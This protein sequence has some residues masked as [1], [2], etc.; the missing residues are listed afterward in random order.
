M[1]LV[2][3][4]EPGRDATETEATAKAWTKNKYDEWVYS[5]V[6]RFVVVK[7][8]DRFC[9][10]I[11]VV[12]YQGQ[13]VAKKGVKKSDHAII[14]T[15]NR[16]PSPSTAEEPEF[17]EAGM[18]SRCIRVDPDQRDEKLDFM[19]RIDFS[20]VQKVQHYCKVK[21]FGKVNRDSLAALEYQY[22]AVLSEPR[23]LAVPSSSMES[24]RVV[25]DGNRSDP[26]LSRPGF[27]AVY[28]AL[29]GVQYTP[30][31][32]MQFLNRRARDYPDSPEEKVE[33]DKDYESETAEQRSEY[34][35]DT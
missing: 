32:A 22:R 26:L 34:T 27:Q 10:A 25:L 21:S 6:R 29:I 18:R 9:M 2:L 5:K 17:G 8:Q 4:S 35:S 33:Y 7:E 13:G 12:T 3:W 31:Q 16:N 14:F 15:G 28:D 19:S 23:T 1:F 11:P 24:Q 30:E 20:A